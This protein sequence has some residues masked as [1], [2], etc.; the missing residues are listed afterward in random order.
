MNTATR[1]YL[2]LLSSGMPPRYA[3]AS[4]W[5][6]LRD[7]HGSRRVWKHHLLVATVLRRLTLSAEEALQS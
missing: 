5:L 2:R 3:A 4:V 1:S 7:R 6:Y